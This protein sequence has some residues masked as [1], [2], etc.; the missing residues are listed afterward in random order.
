LTCADDDDG[1]GLTCADDDDGT[2]LTCADDDDGTRL[3]CAD[4]DDGTGLT[5]LKKTDFQRSVKKKWSR[6]SQWALKDD[7][8]GDGNLDLFT[9]KT[10][11]FRDL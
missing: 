8:D 10:T 9:K 5:C 1:D 4:D 7:D 2:R 6:D 11:T 3:T